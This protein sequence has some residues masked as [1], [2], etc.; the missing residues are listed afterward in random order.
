VLVGVPI[1][2]SDEHH[3]RLPKTVALAVFASDAISSTAYA[4]Q[5]ILLVLVP[6]AGMAALEDIIPIA[7]VVCLLLAIVVT[8]YRQTIKAYPQGGGSYVVSRENLGKMPSLVAGASILV[9][10]VLTVV[11]SVSAGVAA[12]DSAFPE[13]LEYRVPLCLGFITLMTLANL[14]GMKE[15]GRLFAGPTYLYVL[16]LGALIIVGL[17][18]SYLGDIGVLPVNEEALNEITDNGALLTGTT[19]LILLR[20]FSSGAVALTGVEAIADGV[21]AFR[22]PE[23][24]NAGITLTWMAAILGTAFFGLA[25][26]THRLQPTVSHEETLL[27]ILGT[28]VFGDGSAMYYVLQFS[29]FAIL[30]LA[31]NTAFADFPR[32]SSIISRDGYLPRQ[33]ANRGDRLVFSNGIVFLAGLAALLIVVFDGD[34]AAL[35]PL[36][37]VGVFT[38]FTLSQFGMFRFQRTHRPAGWKHRSTISL[39]GAT[40]TFVVALVVVVSKFTQGAWIPAVVIPAIVCLFLQIGRHYAHVRAAI[41]VPPGWRAKRHTHNVVVLV[42]GVNKGVLQALTYARSLAPDRLIAVSVVTNQEEQ[43]AILKQWA[44]HDIHVELH[45]LHSAYRELTRPVLRYLDEIDSESQDDIITVIIPEFVVTHWYTNV[46]HNQSALAL[47]ARLLY[48]PNTVVTS[49]PIIVD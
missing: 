24:K 42:G 3:Q 19:A 46:L 36:Y 43:D 35:I 27:S 41:S 9:D 30:I 29:T 10:Y 47:K 40:A 12:I 14:R 16:A 25:V 1:A 34:T 31:A 38:S 45:T 2:S 33:M 7:L 20:A 28:A 23:A 21:P 6:V 5:E 18:R 22:R 17:V 44:E 4:T 39:I 26:L 49:V 13:L 48:R 15:S 32:L 8:S 37:A 11:V